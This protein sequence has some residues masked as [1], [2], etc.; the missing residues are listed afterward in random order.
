MNLENTQSKVAAHV[1]SVE[2]DIAYINW[3]VLLCFPKSC[4]HPRVTELFA[5]C[6]VDFTRWSRKTKIYRLF[7]GTAEFRKLTLILFFAA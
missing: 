1:Q 4:V 7:F 2:L 5:I 3:C 6:S